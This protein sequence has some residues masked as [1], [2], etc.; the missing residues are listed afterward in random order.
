[1][2][3]KVFINDKQIV[4]CHVMGDQSLESITMMGEEVQFFLKKLKSQHRPLLILDDI[5]KLG[6][7]P[8]EGRKAVIQ[9]VKTL[10]YDRLVMLGN[11]GLIRIG[12]N[13][14]LRASGR[15]GKVRYFTNR[16]ES[17]AWLLK[18]S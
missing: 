18:N 2:R 12:A 16:A 5:T 11:N 15:S 1:M 6:D 13:L 3:N 8:P 4:E 17:V 7:V 14:I 9:Q 10:K